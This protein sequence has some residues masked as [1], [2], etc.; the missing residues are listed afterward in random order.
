[1]C[2]TTIHARLIR[3]RA[4]LDHH[5]SDLYVLVTPSVTDLLADA[6]REGHAVTYFTSPLDGRRWADIPFAY[7]PW[8]EDRRTASAWRRAAPVRERAYV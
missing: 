4:T 2:S 6:K 8:W 7:D 3:A 5:E 1:M